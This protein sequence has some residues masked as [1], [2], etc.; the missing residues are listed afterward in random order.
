MNLSVEMTVAFLNLSISKALQR[1][2]EKCHG[3]TRSLYFGLAPMIVNSALVS[4]MLFF[5]RNSIYNSFVSEFSPR[6]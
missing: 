3:T 4:D 5:S 2:P 6:A 1:S